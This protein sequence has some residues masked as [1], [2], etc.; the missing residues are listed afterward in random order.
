MLRRFESGRCLI[1]LI[2]KSSQWVSQL[3]KLIDKFA[4]ISNMLSSIWANVD[5][6]GGQLPVASFFNHEDISNYS[7]SP[8]RYREDIVAP[9]KETVEQLIRKKNPHDMRL[10]LEKKMRLMQR[11]A[12]ENVRRRSTNPFARTYITTRVAKSG[13]KK[14][15]WYLCSE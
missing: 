10:R 11:I 5:A 2:F 4:H 6:R 8:H 13:N 1:K 12:R 3:T 15:I 7:P 14:Y 9:L